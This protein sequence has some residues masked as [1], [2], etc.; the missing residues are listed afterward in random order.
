MDTDIKTA[1]NISDLQKLPID[2]LIGILEDYKSNSGQ[3][4]MLLDR[5]MNPLLERCKTIQSLGL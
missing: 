1:F 4:E 5:I 2:Q 3:P